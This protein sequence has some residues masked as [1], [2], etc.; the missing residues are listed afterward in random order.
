MWLSKLNRMLE[1]VSQEF[2]EP[3]YQGSLEVSG[4]RLVGK[5]NK[6]ETRLFGLVRQLENKMD[7]DL[8]THEALHSDPSHS[9]E[10]CIK[11][12]IGQLIQEA[13]LDCVNE[14]LTL[15]LRERLNLHESEFYFNGHDIYA[16]PQ[17]IIEGIRSRFRVQ[18]QLKATGQDSNLLDSF[19]AEFLD[20]I[21]PK[22][23]N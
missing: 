2:L 13:E 15:S 1:E 18:K 9:D 12:G 14:I 20:P 11:F 22:K 23:S 19:P 16:Y 10:S 3:D 7:L 6:G 8:N 5:L 4:A 17:A 21:D